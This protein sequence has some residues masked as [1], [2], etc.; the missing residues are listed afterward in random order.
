[1]QFRSVLSRIG[2]GAPSTSD[3]GTAERPSDLR[4]Q[5]ANRRPATEISILDDYF[6]TLRPLDCF[7]KLAGHEV[8]VWNDHVQDVDALAERSRGIAER[9]STSHQVST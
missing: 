3:T 2:G 1:V 7:M 5:L 4:L 8:E 6:D 9:P